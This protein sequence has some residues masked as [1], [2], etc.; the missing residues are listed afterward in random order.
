[1]EVGG[2]RVEDVTA[3]QLPHRNQVE[4]GDQDSEPSGEAQGVQKDGRIRADPREEETAQEGEDQRFT[5]LKS[6][7]GE[8]GFHP[9]EGE[10]P[11]QNREGEEKAQ[12]G[13]CRTDVE[14]GLLGVDRLFDA[15]HGAEGSHEG[16]GGDEERKGSWD[17]VSATG[18]VVTQLVGQ[19]DRHEGEGVGESVE[20]V[21]GVTEEEAQEG[22]VDRLSREEEGDLV[23]ETD[24]GRGDQ[25]DQKEE[26]VHPPPSSLARRNHGL[27]G[28]FLLP[29][30]TNFHRGIIAETTGE[31]HSFDGGVW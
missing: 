14:E 1:M 15:D 24:R 2:D 16:R 9:R 22:L 18:E 11:G 7:S 19:Q 25:G 3:V 27:F 26:E 29:L 31:G 23:E 6:V 4:G 20:P 8:T 30:P 10:P 5:E 21:E 28:F 13:A 12:Q 17:S